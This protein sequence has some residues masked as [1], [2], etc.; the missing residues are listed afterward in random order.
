[1]HAGLISCCESFNS[2]TASINCCAGAH[3][4]RRDSAGDRGEGVATSARG[5]QRTA[6]KGLGSW[7]SSGSSPPPYS[8]RTYGMH[9]LRT[10]LG[11]VLLDPLCSLLKREIR[12][13]AGHQSLQ[14]GASSLRRHVHDARQCFRS[15]PRN[16][17]RA[18]GAAG[19]GKGSKWTIRP[20][21]LCHV[22][23]GCAS[24]VLGE[25]LSKSG[26]ATSPSDEMSMLHSGAMCSD[27]GYVRSRWATHF[28]LTFG[29]RRC[30]SL[31]L[32][33]RGVRQYERRP[34]VGYQT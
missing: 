12:S 26:H 32:P 10:R 25:R 30:A 4:T 16:V 15:S 13:D 19:A 6:R 28:P 18:A 27:K 22:G 11:K 5:V 23:N 1:M 9:F 29:R 7:E 21:L 24:V 3:C 17:M 33:G 14:R 20:D 2:R 31:D 8:R 34:E